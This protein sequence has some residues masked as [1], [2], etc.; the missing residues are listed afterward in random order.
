MNEL[1]WRF[2]GLMTSM[3]VMTLIILLFVITGCDSTVERRLSPEEVTGTAANRPTATLKQSASEER[4]LVSDSG[5]M[6]LRWRSDPYNQA[7]MDLYQSI[8]DM[9]EQEMAGV[10]LLYEPADKRHYGYHDLLKREIAISEGP[11]VFWLADADLANFAMRGMILDLRPLAD[12]DPTYSNSDFHPGA[13]SQLTYNPRTGQSG[14]VLWGLP[15]DVSTNV[16]YINVDLIRQAGAP[17]PRVLAAEGKWNW[18]TF[19]QVA[20]A[21]NEQG[22]EIQGYGESTSWDAYGYWMYASGGSFYNEDGTGC[23]LDSQQALAGLGFQ[24]TLYESGM[25]LP[26]GQNPAGPFLAGKL[27]MF[28]ESRGA[29]NALRSSNLPFTW[30]VVKVPDGPAGATSWVF[31]S[32]YVVNLNTKHPKA[33]Y[34][35]LRALTRPDV[36]LMISDVDA[37]IPSRTNQE[38]IDTFLTFTPPYNNQAYIQALSENP[39][40]PLPLWNGNWRQYVNVMNIA[41]SGVLTG[42]QPIQE[43]AA[44]IC[45]QVTQLFY[46]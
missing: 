2:F 3:T 21:I 12:A 9:L 10:R 32:G 25:A 44:G 17:D 40:T 1:N 43:H 16:L 11:D 45:N 33:A 13:M 4:H 8:N 14:E 29:T 41:M 18:D 22:E 5:E 39:Q 38:V 42:Q 28:L 24:R 26:Y 15:R 34:K 7:E 31:W 19:L 20:S 37:K 27:G 30:D 35:L 6:V 23:G 36:Q 46:Q